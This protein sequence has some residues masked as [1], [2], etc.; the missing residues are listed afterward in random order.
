M[1]IT[2]F[3]VLAERDDDALASAVATAIADGWDVLQGDATGT[4][5]T[6]TAGKFLITLYGYA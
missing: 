2:A 5:A 4:D 3:Q 6:Y 1:A